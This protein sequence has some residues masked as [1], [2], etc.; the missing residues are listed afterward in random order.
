MSCVRKRP[1][2][3][4]GVRKLCSGRGGR[5]QTQGRRKQEEPILSRTLER[6]Q[7][8]EQPERL[9]RLEQ[10]GTLLR[11]L[12]RRTVEIVL[13]S[14][15]PRRQELLKKIVEKFTVCPADIDESGMAGEDPVETARMAA[16]LK[17]K[18]VAE[19]FP[20]AV[21]IGADTIVSLGGRIFGK[22]TDRAQAREML[23]HLSGSRHRV[24]TGVALYR[25][26]ED[27][28]LSDYEIT[29]VTFR[30][31]S[32]DDIEKYLESGDFA[33]KAG[34]YAV[35]EIGDRFVAEMKGDYE[36]V[37]GF[38]VRKVSSL[39]TRFTAP[40]FP[41]EITDI[42]FPNN[43]GVGRRDNAVFFV[44]AA[45]PGD[46]VDV[47]LVQKRA[48]FS[49]GEIAGIEKPSAFRI[50]PKC[51][52]FGRC[53]GCM[54]QNLQ[55][56]KQVELKHKY[57]L[58]TLRRIGGVETDGIEVRPMTPSPESFHYRNK[59]EFGFGT[60]DGRVTLG[61]R[62]RVVPYERYRRTTV[63]ISQCLI[64][65][66]VVEKVFPLF[67]EYAQ[68][69]RLT[70]YDCRTHRG[71]LRHLVLRESKATG[72]CM[73]I[74]VTT[75]GE[76]PDLLA[77]GE[78]LS[79]ALPQT[80]SFYHVVNNQVS[81]VVHFDRKSLVLGS[82]SIRE[83]I[84]EFVFAIH[85]QTFFQP[86]TRA[87]GLLYPA[88]ADIA[89]IASGDTVIGLYCGSGPIEIFL[90]R[91]AGRIVGIDSGAANIATAQENCR[92]NRIS[93]CTFHEGIVERLLKRVSME[94]VRTAVVDPPRAG[95]SGKAISLLLKSA[96]PRIV[97]V[98]CNP[99]SLARDVRIFQDNGYRLATV[100]PFDMFPHTA[101]LETVSVLDRKA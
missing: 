82:G 71:F 84:G 16:V 37:V 55:Y 100:A 31:L 32:A 4:S 36:N 50:S 61:L 13:A 48:G 81:D 39:L 46:T 2:H 98:S 69:N 44:P 51:P 101:H 7:R 21:V 87:A 5:R 53:G 89:G 42:A 26:D 94:N 73:V 43:W 99:A 49:Y 38:P 83:R 93:N 67:L 11:Q 64:F 65:S 24:I 91:H 9:E 6:L 18:K 86:N 62:E 58:E 3:V 77:L 72:D 97:Y 60:E 30:V 15:S 76:L 27:R 66:P 19:T 22:P 23:L 52:H 75:E 79:A 25:K 92:L 88:V 1:C 17:A 96:V 85:P 28:L 78:T 63:P 33:D 74:L 8:C 34:S 59:M 40:V 35:Q 29:T 70:A 12:K 80:K 41:L 45:L 68:R 10:H 90:S 56:D 57:L 54:F 20:H 95:L 47:R 14:R